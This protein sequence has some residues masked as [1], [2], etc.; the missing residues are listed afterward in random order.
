[1]ALACLLAVLFAARVPAQV[2]Q[3]PVLLPAPQP[4]VPAPSPVSP[5]AATPASEEVFISDAPVHLDGTLPAAPVASLSDFVG[6]RYSSSSIDWI[7]GDGD[8]FGM[9][10]LAWDHYQRSG[11]TSGVGLGMQFH[12]LAGPEQTDLPP[13][14]FD[15][16]A[17]YQMR[18][19]LGPLRYD[20]AAAVVASSDFEGSARDGIRF[21]SHAVGYLCIRP[22]VELVFGVDYLDRGDV[23]LLPV[24]G[25]ILTPDPAMRLELV[26]PRPRIAFQ[27]TEEHRLYVSGEL[28]GGTWAIERDSLVDDLATYR[29]LR[30]CI[31]VEH[32]DKEG[33]R[34]AFEIGYLFDRRLEYASGIGD[35]P[36]DDALMLRLVTTF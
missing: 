35:M 5:P 7:V 15:F 27:L 29:D 2:A 24:A 11:I 4:V 17:S 6:Y 8:Q 20:L 10:S 23:K 31:G 3:G 1:M 25:L 36:L 16:S 34:S 30:A 28:G 18:D 14:V 33:G 21:P 19:Q 9:V 26:F 13:R 12:F 32:V 22:E